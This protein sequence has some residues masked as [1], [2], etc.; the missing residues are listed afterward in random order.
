M[1]WNNIGNFLLSSNFSIFSLAFVATLSTI[2]LHSHM[3]GSGACVIVQ[4][5]GDQS[6]YFIHGSHIKL[7]GHS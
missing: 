5:M 4:S 1:A 7:I 6:R 2:L 3:N